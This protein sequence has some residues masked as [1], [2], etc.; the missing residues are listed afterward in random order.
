MSRKSSAYLSVYNDSDLL[1]PAL[2]SIAPMIDELVVVDGAYAWMADY[3]RALGHDPLRSDGRVYDVIEAAGIPYRV[4]AR[5]WSNE[6]EKR[7]AGYAACSHRYVYRIDADEVLTFDTAE[8]ERF[9]ATGGAVAD[10]EM[11]IY[12]APGLIR[13]SVGGE[14]IERQCLLFDREQIPA[15]LHLNYLWLVLTADRLPRAD[16]RPLPIHP[17]PIA[18]NAHLTEWRCPASAL[19][20]ASFYTLNYMRAHGVPW[21]PE[22]RGVPLAD[23]RALFDIVAPDQFRDI[24]LGSRLV[25]GNAELEAGL[26]VGAS[27]LTAAQEAGFVAHYDRLAASLVA[28]NRSF[29]ERWHAFVTGERVTIDLGTAAALEALTA[30]VQIVFEFSGNVAQ[31]RVELRCLT[32]FAPWQAAYGLPHWRDGP[33]LGVRI[34]AVERAQREFLRRKL[35]FQI[36]MAPAQPVQAFRVCLGARN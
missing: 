19:T 5:L 28:L 16:G 31:A 34:P 30:D 8:V 1:A 32:A 13:R 12:L 21:L 9:F 24:L 2:R 35:E 7:Q 6:V 22:L 27:P 20:R 15:D 23:P 11:P 4:V 3:C 26:C 29:T 17:R 14:A 10:M 33:F 36:W 18:F 25:A